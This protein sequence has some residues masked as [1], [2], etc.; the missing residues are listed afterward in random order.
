RGIELVRLARADGDARAE[1][2]EHLGHLQAEPARAAGDEGDLALE[3]EEPGEAH[4]ALRKARAPAGRFDA[5]FMTRASR[6]VPAE[7][8]VARDPVAGED[9]ARER[10]I[11]GEHDGG[12]D[13]GELVG[14]ALA[15]AAHHLE[16][17]PLRRQTG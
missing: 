2:A 7:L 13:L 15:V 1:L 6:P 11:A 9:G 16:A 10:R 4:A 12:A 3:I 5:A 14:L 8:V 17:F